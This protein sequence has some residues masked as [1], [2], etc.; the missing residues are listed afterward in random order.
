MVVAVGVLA[1]HGD[2]ERARPR[3]A[4]IFRD[5]VELELDAALVLSA[6]EIQ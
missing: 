1:L 6:G 5:R 2:E 3:A 4:G